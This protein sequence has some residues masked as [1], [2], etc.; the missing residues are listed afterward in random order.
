[1]SAMSTG[2]FT[3]ERP[4]P[5]PISAADVARLLSLDVCNFRLPSRGA[6]SLRFAITRQ[7]AADAGRIFLFD[8]T[9]DIPR[10][11]DTVDLHLAFLPTQGFPRGVLLADD[12]RVELRILFV[13]GEAS[14]EGC[15]EVENLLPE[16][17]ARDRMWTTSTWSDGWD[18][19]TAG[20]HCLLVVQPAT[21]NPDLLPPYNFPVAR[22]DVSFADL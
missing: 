21:R 3:T 17:G 10:N 16:L 4:T 22:V 13:A 19:S 8:E 9:F 18:F 6:V 1:M 5:L 7:S 15:F 2:G 14:V 11:A 20:S 12:P